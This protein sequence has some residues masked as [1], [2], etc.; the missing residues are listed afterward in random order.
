MYIYP[1]VTR[2]PL[3]HV[4]L[5]EPLRLGQAEIVRQTE[6]GILVYDRP[7][8]LLILSARDL[9]AAEALLDGVERRYPADFFLLCDE[10]LAPAI[11]RF[12]LPHTMRCRQAAYLK[13]ERPPA[14]PRL[15][16][17]VPGEAAFARILTAYAMDSP[18]ELERR[19]SAGEL[20]FA[21]TTD[22]EDVG[23]AGLHA[24]GCFG[25]LEV[26]PEQ[27][28]RG[29]GAAL[30]AHILRFCLDAGRI[31]YCQVEA[32]NEVSLNLQRKLGLEIS[33]RIMLMTWNEWT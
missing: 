4:C 29:Y 9:S 23:F 14:D 11:A 19:R 15:I 10:A 20:F 25:L 1:E 6:R 5:T 13:K 24:E 18:A 28:G 7:G 2:E 30:E 22:G 27:R 8:K 17:E 3:L 33:D 12:G 32:E 16:I 26:F 31:P 21:R